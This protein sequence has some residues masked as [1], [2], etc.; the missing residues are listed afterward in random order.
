MFEKYYTAVSKSL[1]F[2]NL[3]LKALPS[4]LK[5]LDPKLKSYKKND[6]IFISGDSFTGIGIIL[7]G[8]AAV[9]NEKING[10]RVIITTLKQGDV[11]GEMIA[12]SGLNKW[13][14][15]IKAFEKC[16]VLMLP[17]ARIVGECSKVCPWHRALIEN[18]LKLLSEKALMLNSK[19]EYLAI[20]G[21]REKVSTY[22][23]EQYKNTGS[24]NIVLNFN[25][26]EL[27]DFLN[28]SRPSM[29][30]ELCKMRDECIIDFHLK[31]FKILNLKALK[32]MNAL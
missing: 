32:S 30:R 25:R 26:N 19:V 7:E 18:F 12:F 2:N 5:C 28:V 13:L 9:L 4:M 3:D 10:D 15:T 23:Y 6:Y 8:T 29:S 11:F 22:L 20:K 27:A 17:K 14:N 24:S 31:S 16:K 1:L 21:I